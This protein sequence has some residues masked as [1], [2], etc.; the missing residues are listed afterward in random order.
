MQSYMYVFKRAEERVN[1]TTI[2]L[3]ALNANNASSRVWGR[4]NMSDC[5][6]IVK[7]ECSMFWFDQRHNIAEFVQII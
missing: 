6:D 3:H 5:A 2:L 4:V 1:F 7:L